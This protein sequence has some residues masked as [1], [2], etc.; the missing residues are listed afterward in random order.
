MK[1]EGLKIIMGK[2]IIS[3]NPVKTVERI[4]F[5]GNIIDPRTRQV[6]VPKEKETLTQA[7]P[8]QPEYIATG[9]TQEAVEKL[10]NYKKPE[11]DEPCEKC[12]KPMVIRTGKYGEFLSCSGYPDC[13]NIRK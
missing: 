4:D 11:R 13:K 10:N 5:N 12:G 7:P 1:P 8:P 2:T 9:N 3:P 6:I